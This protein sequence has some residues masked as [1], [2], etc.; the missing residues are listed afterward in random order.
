MDSLKIIPRRINKM[1]DNFCECLDPI[2]RT[3]Q[4]ASPLLSTVYAIISYCYISSMEIKFL[5]TFFLIFIGYSLL[6]GL[7]EIT[8]KKKKHSMV[9]NFV[10]NIFYILTITVLSY[11][12][13]T[14]YIIPLILDP[15]KYYTAICGY[16]NTNTT[17][18]SKLFQIGFLLCTPIFIITNIYQAINKYMKKPKYDSLHI[19]PSVYKSQ[20]LYRRNEYE[21]NNSKSSILIPL[22]GMIGNYF[23]FNDLTSYGL[24]IA[25]IFDTFC[26]Y[27]EKIMSCL[28]P[29]VCGIVL[30]LLSVFRG[31]FKLANVFM[32][33]CT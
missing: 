32:Y 6:N 27:D 2:K 9:R 15:K 28:M 5:N 3:L 4:T 24:C 22:L 25:S 33:T 18:F 16:L 23:T 10:L 1:L 31:Y 14:T 7:Y 11:Y 29:L 19:Y 13:C 12:L 26:V 30:S 17:W 8:A 21:R 20:L